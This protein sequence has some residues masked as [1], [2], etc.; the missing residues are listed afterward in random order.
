MTPTV[1][2]A[3]PDRNARDGLCQSLT[4][5]GYQVHSAEGGVQC[6]RLLNELQPDLLVLDLELC[7]GGADGVLAVMREDPLLRHIPV[8]VTSSA[9]QTFRHDW[10]SPP[11]VCTLAKPYPVQRL[12]DHLDSSAPTAG[13]LTLLP[14]ASAGC[15]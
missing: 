12:L 7:W 14:L 6:L 15:G 10:P 8:A 5:R 11:V 13:F 1:L 4:R 2:I 3:D 9:T